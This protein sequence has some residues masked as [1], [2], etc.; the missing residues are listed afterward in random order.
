M[1]VHPIKD[2][3]VK[4][5][6]SLSFVK[7]IAKQFSNHSPLPDSI[8]SIFDRKSTNVKSEGLV[9]SEQVEFTREEQLFLKHNQLEY[10]FELPDLHC[11]SNLLRVD[12]EHIHAISLKD[13]KWI[14]QAMNQLR[15]NDP[16]IPYLHEMLR[17][18]NIMAPE[19]EIMERNSKLEERCQ[20]LRGQQEAREYKAMTSN[21]DGLQTHQLQDTISFQIKQINR[22][23][24]AVAQF[25]FSVA[26]GFAFGFIGIELIVGQ[27]DLGFRLLLGIM[28]ALIIALAEI[29]F[30]AKKLNEDY[31]VTMETPMFTSGNER[32]VIESIKIATTKEKLHLD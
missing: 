24:I 12:H 14:N 1:S 2:S 20:K 31:D 19:N 5:V 26:A 25:I 11:K 3:S 17:D 30:L 32:K 23:L 9:H 8:R 16:S 7:F 22:Q 13:L 15:N 29:Y 28:I 4:I 10:G 21:V 27:L 6:L 18:C